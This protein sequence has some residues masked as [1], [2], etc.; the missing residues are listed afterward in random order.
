MH[1][2]ASW[3]ALEDVK[4][5]AGELFYYP[6]SQRLPDYL[7]PGENKNIV[8]AQ[9]RNPQLDISGPI[10]EHVKSLT[11]LCAREGIEQQRFVAKAGDVLIW[12]A[13]IVHGGSSISLDATRRSIVTHYCPKELVPLYFEDRP[14][15][16]RFDKSGNPYTTHVY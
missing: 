16:I 11:D 10:A 6:G 1:L 7:Y 2:A 12:A 5:G 3:I 8:D 14:R 4:P 9:R 13:D 15:E